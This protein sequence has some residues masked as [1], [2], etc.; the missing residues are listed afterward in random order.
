MPSYTHPPMCSTKDPYSRG[1][2]AAMRDSGSTVNVAFRMSTLQAGTRDA[3]DNPALEEQEHREQRQPAEDRGRHDVGI[4]DPVRPLDRGQP[5][6]DRHEVR[7]GEHEQRPQ[8]V[9][10][11]PDERED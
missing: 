1:S 3:L 10:P 4:A 11:A 9:V 6:R 8:Q 2:T 5:D 7:V